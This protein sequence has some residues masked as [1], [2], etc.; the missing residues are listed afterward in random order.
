VPTPQIDAATAL[1]IE[2][3]RRAGLYR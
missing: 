1:V 3:A 2:K